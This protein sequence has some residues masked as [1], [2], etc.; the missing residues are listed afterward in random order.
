MK[1]ILILALVVVASLVFAT[2]AFAGVTSTYSTW[3]PAYPN[4][5]PATPHKGYAINTDKCAVC[6]QSTRVRQPAS[7]FFAAPWLMHARTA[8]SIRPQ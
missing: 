7:C 4:D 8:T 3:N 1:K 2:S 5:N 6:Q